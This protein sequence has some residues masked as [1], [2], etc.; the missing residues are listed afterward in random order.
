MEFKPPRRSSK[1]EPY[2]P[3]WWE[4]LDLMF[5]QTVGLISQ[6]MTPDFSKEDWLLSLKL[7]EQGDIKAT[8]ICYE[9]FKE[10]E[11]YLTGEIR[12]KLLKNI[13]V[14]ENL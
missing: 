10:I 3:E 12:R 9:K 4:E 8:M 5:E 7:A 11:P 1:Y 2:S 6:E 14:G 13:P